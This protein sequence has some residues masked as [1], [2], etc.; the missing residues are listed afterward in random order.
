MKKLLIKN[1]VNYHYEIIESVIVKCHEILDIDKTISIDI[2]LYILND[3][4]FNKYIIDKYPSI[5]IKEI[6]NYDY[7]INCTIY[8]NDFINLDT[9]KSNK[10]YIS[11][12]ITDRLKKNP[13]VLFLTPLSINNF[14]Y[15]DV[16]PFSKKKKLSK[17]PI[18]IIQGNLNHNRRN[19]SLLKKILDN[20]Y[21]YNFIFKLIGRGYLPKNLEKYKKIILFKNNL[22]FIDYHKEFLDCY[23]I[24]PLITKQKHPKYYTNKLTSTINY[25]RGYKLKCLIDKNLQDI[26]NL[27]DVEIFNDIN[28]ISMAF[29][30][31]LDKFYNSN[32]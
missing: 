20:N 14:F 16:M 30:K 28:D 29:K 2:Y 15:A 23:C 11:H 26:Y 6:N 10:K 21:K 27:D 19:L 31:T 17:I 22:K 12:E 13:N 5:K 4:S 18:Y 32:I 8:D 3:K 7:Y 24:L 25:A 1:N 9:Q